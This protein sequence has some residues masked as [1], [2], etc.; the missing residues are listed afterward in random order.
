MIYFKKLIKIP[1]PKDLGMGD[2]NHA[3]AMEHFCNDNTTPTWESYYARIK[4]EYPIKYFFA[5]TMAS[6]FMKRYN[7]ISNYVYEIFYYLKCHFK[8]SH[9]YHKLDLSQPKMITVIENDGSV[10]K[11][12]NEDYYS[13]GWLDVDV[14]MMYAIFNL[15]NSYVENELKIITEEDI[16]KD[17]S[18]ISYKKDQEEIIAIHHWWNVER[19]VL[20]QENHNL[21][22][23]WYFLSEAKR[24]DAAQRASKEVQD[25]ETAFN[26]KTDEMIDR[27]MKIRRK[28][29]S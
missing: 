17:P 26:N 7:K 8:R 12:N 10:N 3:M 11:I 6:F 20:Q 27:L 23:K 19:K 15:L 1:G 5:S 16:A 29:W 14:R 4:R 21:T 13:Y 25:F 24:K 2:S 18:F 22:D 9:Q 28:L